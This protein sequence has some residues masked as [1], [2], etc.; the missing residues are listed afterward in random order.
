M[1][2][3]VGASLPARVLVWVRRV[4]CGEIDAFKGCRWT[5]RFLGLSESDIVGR[6]AVDYDVGAE[7]GRKRIVTAEPLNLGAV[8]QLDWSVSERASDVF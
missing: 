4:V 8:G 3:D 6:V 5:F 1:K 2:A 7:R